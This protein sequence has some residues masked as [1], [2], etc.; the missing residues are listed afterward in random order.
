MTQTPVDLSE[1]AVDPDPLRQF[2]AWFADARKAGEPL[3]EAMT[4]ATATRDGGPSARMVSPSALV[5][6]FA[7][8]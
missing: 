5:A 7:L 6:A 4:L 3:P 8:P 2:A 1:D